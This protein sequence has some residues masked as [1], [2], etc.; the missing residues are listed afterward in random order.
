MFW[1]TAY[2]DPNAYA[3]INERLDGIAMAR[4]HC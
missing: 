2:F 1:P 3:V 4:A